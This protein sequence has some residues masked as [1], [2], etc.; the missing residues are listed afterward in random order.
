MPGR[1]SRAGQ[2]LEMGR[3][4]ELA[5]PGDSAMERGGD[6]LAASSLQPDADWRR[7]DVRAAE[8]VGH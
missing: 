2:G 5:M 6:G 3:K 8:L 4:V 1:S 7:G